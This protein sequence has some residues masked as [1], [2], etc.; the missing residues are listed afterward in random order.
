MSLFAFGDTQLV[1]NDVEEDV[2][3]TVA[4]TS[5]DCDGDFARV[6]AAGAVAIHEPED[7]PWGVRGAFVQGPGKL[8]FE[9]EQSLGDWTPGA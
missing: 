4:F 1:V 7:K 3:S 9:F 2:L 6:V 5:T 8:I